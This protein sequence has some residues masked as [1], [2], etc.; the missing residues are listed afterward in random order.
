MSAQD[1]ALRI[2]RALARPA[3][4][5]VVS[6]LLRPAESVVASVA[7]AGGRPPELLPAGNPWLAVVTRDDEVVHLCRVPDPAAARGTDDPPPDRR[8]RVDGPEHG[9]RPG[10]RPGGR[11]VVAVPFTS[12]EELSRSHIH[13]L[14]LE[15]GAG[16]T[17]RQGLR[18][19]LARRLRSDGAA[20][21]SIDF[22]AIRACPQWPAVE[23]LL[24]PAARQDR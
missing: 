2:Q 14:G 13:V 15:P 16:P 4:H 10:S 6:L 1:V 9:P 7:L 21:H 8:W 23:R 19:E 17:T 12:L 20:V 11:V 24:D 18:G 22:A 3:R 5:L